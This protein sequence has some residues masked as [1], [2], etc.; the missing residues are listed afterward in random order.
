MLVRSLVIA[1]L[2]AAA[3][4][5]GP[6]DPSVCHVGQGQ[7]VCPICGEVCRYVRSA[8]PGALGPCEIGEIPEPEF[9]GDASSSTG[10]GEDEGGSAGTWASEG[11]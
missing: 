1:L 2:G 11:L 4:C 6:L 7:G 9:G 10:G 8:D 5:G 3:Q